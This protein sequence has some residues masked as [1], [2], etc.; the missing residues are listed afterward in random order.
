MNVKTDA[1]T[2]RSRGFAFVIFKAVDSVQKVCL[3]FSSNSVL[4]F[5]G[6]NIVQSSHF[7]DAQVL[8]EGEH[9]IGKKRVEAKP[10]KARQGKIF[11]GGLPIE[12]TDEQVKEYFQKYGKVR[13]ILFLFGTINQ[14]QSSLFLLSAIQIDTYDL[15]NRTLILNSKFVFVRFKAY[16]WPSWSSQVTD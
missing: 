5:V 6:A 15:G 4:V 16:H 14:G 11:V 7:T 10:A 8:A 1:V 3:S 12:L 13:W 2:G 9:V